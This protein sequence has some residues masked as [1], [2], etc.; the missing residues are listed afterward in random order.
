L[1]DP[2]SGYLLNDQI[3]LEKEEISKREIPLGERIVFNLISGHNFE[4]KHLYFDN[5]FTSLGLLEKLNLQN[6]KTSGTIRT[7]RAGIPSNFAKKD[8]IEQGDYKSMILSSSIVFIWVDTKHVFLASNYH[9]DNKVVP[10]FR[11]STS[12]NRL[13]SVCTWS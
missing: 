3:Y 1:C 12:N 10:I 4:G 2:I 5:F 8:K 7:D 9:K 6:I 11:R 13:Q